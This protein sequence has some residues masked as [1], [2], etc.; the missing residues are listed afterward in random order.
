MVAHCNNP[1]CPKVR[2]GEIHPVHDLGESES[3][4]QNQLRS[5]LHAGADIAGG[6]IGASTGLLFLGPSGA[7]IGS[8]L[9]AAA[10][11]AIKN[12]AQ[13]VAQRYL[14]DREKA[15]IGAA[16]IF[17][18]EKIQKNLDAGM[19]IRTDDFFQG[20]N[21]SRSSAD[22]IAETVLLAVQRD[23]QEKKIRYFGNLLANI[24]FNPDI[25]LTLANQLVRLGARL[26]YQQLCILALFSQEPRSNY[27]H[28]N[29]KAPGQ[30]PMS[31]IG[32]LQDIIELYNEGMLNA[33]GRAL[34]GLG[35]IEPA[36]MRTQGTGEGL[37]KLMELN[38]IPIEDL[39]KL[40]ETL[41]H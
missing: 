9:G 35:N 34:L 25:D 28:E 13:E 38:E 21:N 2:A 36:K 11:H 16:I 15:R 39:D 22:E 10:A 33:S 23:A 31:L 12:V 1:R 14:G 5:L 18:A 6:A 8:A 4:N 17:T 27:K 26:S 7:A 19:T 32:L 40:V 29:Y 41:N 24:L 20:S 3:N 30:V 37:F